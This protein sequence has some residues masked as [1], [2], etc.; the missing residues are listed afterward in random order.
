MHA[1]EAQH[2][3]GRSC[4]SDSER[5]YTLLHR[6]TGQTRSVLLLEDAIL[7]VHE[8]RAPKR[9]QKGKRKVHENVGR[10]SKQHGPLVLQ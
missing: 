1:I 2:L 6:R 10:P 7:W 8:Q 4:K 5:V 9:A 3:G